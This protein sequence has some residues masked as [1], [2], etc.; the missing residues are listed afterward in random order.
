MTRQLDSS[1]SL[2]EPAPAPPPLRTETEITGGWATEDPRVTILCISYQHEKFIRDCLAGLLG[3]ETDFPFIVHVRD[4]GSTDATAAI[5]QEYRSAY[6]NILRLTLEPVNTYASVKPL[7]VMLPDVTSPYIALCAG[8]DYWTDS[9]KLQ[10]QVAQLDQDPSVAISFHST[11]SVRDGRVVAVRDMSEY[12][13]IPGDRLRRMGALPANTILFR[14]SEVLRHPTALHCL[15]NVWNED[16]FLTNAMGFVGTGQFCPS[17]GPTVYRLHSGGISSAGDADR[18]NLDMVTAA[19]WTSRFLVDMGDIPAA[20]AR[21]SYASR[22]LNQPIRG[23]L[24]PSVSSALHLL[25]RGLAHEARR[26]VSR[27][28]RMIRRLLPR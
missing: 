1:V 18:V 15:R 23:S 21:M 6:P 9:K 16:R 14:N 2:G 10:N 13:I 22:R 5:L 24:S 4:D 26:H 3:Q 17:I 8:D 7:G 11:L 28:G 12:G 27:M 20:R 19:Y 25:Q